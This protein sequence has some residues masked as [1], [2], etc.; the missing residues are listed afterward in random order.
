MMTFSINTGGSEE[1]ISYF[2]VGTNSNS[3]VDY[4]LD[5]LKD[6]VDKEI[7]PQDLRNSV[8]SLFSSVPF[9]ETG[10]GTGSRTW[11]GID[12]INPANRD[13]KG[14][15]IVLGKRGFQG[16]EIMSQ[17]LLNSD[18]DLFIYNTKPD[19]V[20]QN[21]TQIL[22]LAGSNLN[23]H[24]NSPKIQSQVI[25]GT[26]ESRSLDFI[27]TF[28]DIKVNSKSWSSFINDVCVDQ[29]DLLLLDCE[30]YEYNIIKQIN[31]EKI[32]P[33]VIRY[34]YAHIENKN[35]CDNF[36]KLKGY[37]INFCFHDHTFNKVAIL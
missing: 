2:L 1:S 3:A 10:T 9:K 35:E 11:I 16:T 24:V 8:L 13:L 31:F 12:N 21:T 32:K 5:T 22:L 27:N 25:S 36:L 17:T 6:N 14:R 28:G 7:S 15:K 29:I 20:I 33:K 23:L 18:V 34:E 37:K 26:T 19:S 30:G 4:I